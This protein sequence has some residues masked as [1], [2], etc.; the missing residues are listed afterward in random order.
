MPFTEN[1]FY[2]SLVSSSHI[3][4]MTFHSV[5]YGGA[6]LSLSLSEQ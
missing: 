2:S 3:T 1:M 5:V 4:V 6:L